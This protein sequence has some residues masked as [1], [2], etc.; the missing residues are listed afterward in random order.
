MSHEPETHPLT[1]RLSGPE[2]RVAH[3]SAAERRRWRDI[4]MSLLPAGFAILLVASP[5]FAQVVLDAK[6]IV[7]VESG[8]GAT[9]RQ[10][11]SEPDRT[12][13]RVTIIRRGGRYFWTSR[14]DRELLHHLSGA[15]HYFIEPRGGG[16]IKVFDAHTLPE[17]LR[18][19]GP[20]FRY[21]EHL[22]FWLGTITY[23]G[24]SEEFRLD[25][26]EGPANKR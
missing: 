17:S 12:K 9:L 16:Y 6:P 22:T 7:K 20:R 8:E 14:E 5:V 11:L 4:A 26:D 15:F 2:A 13:Y 19:P 24:A 10:L 18:D 23:W 25:A 21:M 3:L 1:P